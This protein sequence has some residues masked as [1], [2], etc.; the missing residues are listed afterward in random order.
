MTPPDNVSNRTLAGLA[1]ALGIAIGVAPAALLAQDTGG[2]PALTGQAPAGGTITPATAGKLPM[3]QQKRG[4]VQGKYK[5]Y[6]PS[7]ISSGGDRPQESISSAT[8]GAGAGKIAIQDKEG[9]NAAQG[10]ASLSDFSFKSSAVQQ[11]AIQGKTI[12]D[13]TQGKIIS[14]YTVKQKLTTSASQVKAAI[15]DK[16]STSLPAVQKGSTGGT[17]PQ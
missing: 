11:K 12:L 5:V 3:V 2:K 16:S 14:A 10:K 8:G 9:P 6:T 15:Q 4:L 7:A 17:A 13:A 1:A